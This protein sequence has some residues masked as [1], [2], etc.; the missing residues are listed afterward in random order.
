MEI[1]YGSMEIGNWRILK[2]DSATNALSAVRLSSLVRTNVPNVAK[3]TFK[4]N[5]SFYIVQCKV[6]TKKGA[7]VQLND[8]PTFKYAVCF[9]MANSF[10]LMFPTSF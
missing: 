3:D 8:S 9:K 5:R 2:S 1:R 10:F 6:I 4:N 7:H